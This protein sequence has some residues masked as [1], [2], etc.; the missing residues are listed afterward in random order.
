M[1]TA[2][3][4]NSPLRPHFVGIF[5]GLI[6][7]IAKK[8]LVVIEIFCTRFDTFLKILNVLCKSEL[9][10]LQEAFLCHSLLHKSMEIH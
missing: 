10:I 5:A 4:N 1:C 9:I 6:V 7:L 2:C 3:K 8:V